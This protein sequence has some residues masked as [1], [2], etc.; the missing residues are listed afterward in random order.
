MISMLFL[1][2]LVGML[3]VSLVLLAAGIVLLLKIKNK[4]VGK[5]VA[6]LALVVTLSPCV[7]YLFLMTTT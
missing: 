4:L 7:M 3:L 1:L 2:P 6:E 5:L